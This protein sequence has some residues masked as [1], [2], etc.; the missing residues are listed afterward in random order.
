MKKNHNLK[1]ESF[2]Y[3]AEMKQLL[4]LIV[5]SLYTHP[6]I[7]IR[8]LVSN[9][10]DA[11]NKMRFRRLTESDILNPE[12]DLKIDI[13]LDKE[14]AVFSIED[15]G[16]GMTKQDLIDNIGTVASSGT[17]NF[18]SQLKEQEKTLD[19]QL[20][21]QFGVGFYSVFM[22][23]DEITIETRFASTDSK[24][25]KWTSKG[26]ENF[27][28][29][30]IEKESRGT[31]ISFKLKDDFKEYAEDYQVKT[32]LKKYS[33]FVDFPVFVNG[34]EVNVV[35]ALW[36]LKK[37]DLK[38]ED[39][40]EFYKFIT[41]D[42]ENP[43]KYLHLSI[44]GNINFKA[45]LFIPNTAPPMLFRDITE[46][47]LHLY[48]SKVFI[49]DDAKDLLPDYL[50]FVR[51]VIDSED[52]SLN[53]SREVTQASPV[54]GKIR[55]ILTS[56]ILAM[57]EE[58][59]KDEP[60]KFK[61]FFAQ[62]GSVFK[63]GISADYTNKDKIVELLL[64]NTS[65]T[66]ADELISL[67][68]YAERMKPEQKEIYFVSGNHRD[69]II[70]NPNLEYFIKNDIEV[71][72]LTDPVDVFTVPYIFNYKEKQLKSIDKADI[73]VGSDSESPDKKLTSDLMDELLKKFKEVLGDRI[74]DAVES[75]R[76]VDSPATLVVGKSGLDPQM[77]KMMQIM[78]KE[79]TASK[80][81]LEINPGHQLIMNLSRINLSEPDSE[82]LNNCILQIYEGAMLNEGY[83]T[84][85]ADYIKRQNIIMEKA[86]K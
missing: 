78:D 40:N 5:H 36:H 37:E 63:T 66:D 82:L 14:N 68:T 76:L 26:E 25:Y 62:F 58:M 51:G 69:I 67:S 79:F 52:V 34:E 2:E 80:R 38:E 32:T 17:L 83:L 75:K 30:E 43:M 15:S 10:S 23:T 42:Y 81:I 18:L 13:T 47:S 71:L 60:D 44:E 21:G 9:A 27:T 73:D 41:Q 39:V 86:T 46:K 31:K 24:A 16:I 54:M 59:K 64:F 33:N 45:L 28:I 70:K 8:E 77:E 85:P 74:E 49:S 53:V 20:I 84:N 29:E 50:K 7:F 35:N 11:L 22:V 65:K 61:H 56:K 12:L 6:E 3:K 48:S 55:N 57:L 1:S 72:F 19:G 4:H